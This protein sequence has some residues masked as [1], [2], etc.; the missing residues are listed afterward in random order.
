MLFLLSAVAGTVGDVVPF[1]YWK[2]SDDFF[3]TRHATLREFC[4][5]GDFALLIGVFLHGLHL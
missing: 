1:S 5:P 4:D 2:A 3:K